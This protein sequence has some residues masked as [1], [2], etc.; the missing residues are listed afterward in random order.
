MNQAVAHS[1]DRSPVHLWL[2]IREC[3]RKR[4]HGFSDDFEASSEGPFQGWIDE[5][6]SQIVTLDGEIIETGA[7]GD[8]PLS[9]LMRLFRMLLDDATQGVCADP[10]SGIG[11]LEV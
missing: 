7:G 8:F 10:L 11:D 1:G 3:D 2:C 6:F 9:S 4:L 5:E